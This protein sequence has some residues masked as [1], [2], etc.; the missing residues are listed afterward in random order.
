MSWIEQ[1]DMQYLCNRRIFQPRKLREG[2]EE[3]FVAHIE[4]E[5]T[6][7]FIRYFTIALQSGCRRV[8]ADFLVESFCETIMFD[9]QF[10]VHLQTHPELRR[11]VEVS[12][13]S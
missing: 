3:F 10:V 8:Y 12:R 4:V 2:K 13:E 9:V 5:A 11:H 6:Q 1:L 7:G